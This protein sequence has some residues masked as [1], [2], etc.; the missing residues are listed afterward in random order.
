MMKSWHIKLNRF[1]KIKPGRAFEIEERLIKETANNFNEFT[2]LEA[3]C[4]RKSTLGKLYS[5]SS[6]IIGIDRDENALRSNTN[7]KVRVIGSLENLPFKDETFNVINCRFV[8]EHLK[9][10]A[11]T[12]RE[13]GRVLTRGGYLLLW[14][15]N[16]LNYAMIVSK[17]T[18][19]LFHNLYRKKLLGVELDNDPTYYKANTIWKLDKMLKRE[20]LQQ[21]RL[22]LQGGAYF[23]LGFSRIS[24]FIGLLLNRITDF[25][26]LKYLRLYI[27]GLYIK[28]KT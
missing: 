14:T 8:M 2:G 12:L 23:Y 16:L 15:V 19:T 6:N 26:F 9:D 21:K 24:Y 3:G 4:G 27:L 17:L 1:F 25:G 20:G 11:E 5:Q 18:P 22:I 7:I 28:P 10:P 13:F